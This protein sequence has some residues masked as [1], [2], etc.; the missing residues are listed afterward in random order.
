MACNALVV[1]KEHL[2]AT[3]IGVAQ[4]QLPSSKAGVQGCHPSWNVCLL[5]VL[6]GLLHVSSSH[7]P[8]GGGAHRQMMEHFA[9]GSCR[10]GVHGGRVGWGGRGQ[11]YSGRVHY[12]E[13]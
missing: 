2:C 11:G 4:Q 3:G 7:V 12:D 5:G 13:C 10:W 1:L 9:V 6:L 8:S